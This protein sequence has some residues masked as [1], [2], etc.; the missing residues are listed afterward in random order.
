[1][2]IHNPFDDNDFNPELTP[3]IDIMFLLLVF[4][5][6]TTTFLKEEERHVLPVE[7][8]EAL[9]SHSIPIEQSI[10]ISVGRRGEYRVDEK[11]CTPEMLPDLLK[12][13]AETD[14]VVVIHA[15]NEAPYKSII[16]LYDIFQSVGIRHF[17]H[18]VK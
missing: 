5:M 3:L 16:Y 17:V 14:T 8:P 1:M 18:D 10:L 11:S 4:F 13:R 12:L 6:L 9:N 2:D 7:L 15:H